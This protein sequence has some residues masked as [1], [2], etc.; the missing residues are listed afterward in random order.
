MRPILVNF[1][2]FSHNEVKDIEFCKLCY[3]SDLRGKIWRRGAESNRRIKVLQT[4]A[5]PLGYRAPFAN[6][7]DQECWGIS[8]LHGKPS[9]TGEGSEISGAGD[10]I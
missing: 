2:K 8:L 7:L 6:L 1:S 3:F 5:L 9:H 10:G 4:S